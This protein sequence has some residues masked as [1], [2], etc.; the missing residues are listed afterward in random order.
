MVPLCFEIFNLINDGVGEFQAFL[1]DN[2][3]F[4]G[5]GVGG[6]GG[7]PFYGVIFAAVKLLSC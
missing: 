6:Q 1:P 4:V 5:K 7:C 2:K 3:V